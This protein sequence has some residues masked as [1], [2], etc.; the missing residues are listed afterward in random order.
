MGVRI[1]L[2]VA[3]LAVG[4]SSAIMGCGGKTDSPTAESSAPSGWRTAP[5]AVKATVA[6]VNETLNVP[7]FVW[8]SPPEKLPLNSTP[9]SI[10]WGTLRGAA[11]SLKLA[12]TALAAAKINSIHDTGS[13]AIVA[14]FGQTV[15]GLDVFRAELNVSMRRDLSPVAISGSLAPS[16]RRLSAN[17]WSVD[18]RAA[19][20]AAFQAMTGQTVATSS[21]AS[22]GAAAGGFEHYA[23]TV[24]GDYTQFANARI[25]RVWFPDASGIVPAYYVELELANSLNAD[26]KLNSF[27]IGAGKADT[28]YQH[29]MVNADK[30]SYRVWA[31]NTGPNG[32]APMD[33]PYGNGLTPNAAGV[34]DTN[35]LPP[36]YVYSSLVNLQ[37]I[38]FS[39]NDPWLPMGA[40]DLLGGNNVG[41]YADLTAPD[42][43][44]AGGADVSVASTSP[45]VFGHVFDPNTIPGA[46]N[47][48]IQAVTTNL[49][50]VVNYMHD[51]FYDSGYD[52][53]SHNSQQDNYGR[54]GAGAL[55]GDPIHAESQDYSGLDNANCSTPSDGKSPRIQ[56][57]LWDLVSDHH[58]T[59]NNPAALGTLTTV[60]TAV[61][62]VAPWDV[63]GD[64]VQY[65]DAKGGAS[66]A[67]GDPAAPSAPPTPGDP[68]NAAN[69]A[70]LAGKIA[71]VDRGT[72]SFSVKA[73]NARAAGAVAVIVANSATGAMLG[74]FGDTAYATLTSFPGMLVTNADGT[75]IKTA[76]G[77]GT[78]NVE[79]FKGPPTRDGSVD[80]T[81]ISH[82]WGHSLSHRLINNANGLNSTQSNG[83]GEG[84]SDFVALLTYIRP[85]DLDVASNAN[86][87]GVYPLGTYALGAM[88]NDIYFGIRRYPYSYDMTKDP[89]TFKYIQNG[90][91]LPTMPPP[92][93]G[94]N[95]ANNAEVHNTGEVWAVMLWDLYV[96]LLRDT[97]NYNFATAGKQMRDYLVASLKLTPSDP[98]FTE[99]R[100]AWLLA[101]LANTAKPNDFTT[102]ATAFARRGIGVGA[103]APPR[104]A[105]DN[106][107][108]TESFMIGSDLE[109]VTASLDDDVSSCDHDHILDNGETGNLTVTMHNNGTNTL[110]AATVKLSSTTA[111]VVFPAGDTVTFASTAPFATA[112]AKVKVALVGVTGFTTFDIK[113]DLDAPNLVPTPGPRSTTQTFY[114]NYDWAPASSATDD[115]NAPGTLWS[116]SH[117][118]TLADGDW[119]RIPATGAFGQL[120]FNADTG[121]T[122]DQYLASP[123]LHVGSGNFSFSFKHHY[124]FEVDKPTMTTKWFDGGV[125]EASTDGTTW[126]DIGA[127][128]T[129][130]GYTASA[131]LFN[132]PTDP[133]P[134]AG[135]P[136]FL[137]ASAGYPADIVTTVDL[138]T[139]YAGSS[140]LQIR[141][142]VGT[143]SGGSAPGWFVDD[144]AFTG[145]TDT[146]FPSRVPQSASCAPPVANAGPAQ[147]VNEGTTAT[148][149]GTASTAAAG[150]TIGYHWSQL[151]GP[152]VTLSSA[153]ASK[154]TFTAPQVN[155]DMVV[156]MQLFVDDGTLMS[157]PSTVD[158]TVKYVPVVVHDMAMG[159]GGTGGGGGG[160]ATDDMGTG[161]AGGGGGGGTGGTGGGGG[162]GH[163]GCSATGSSGTPTAALPFV[164]L[165]LLGFAL[166]RRSRRS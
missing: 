103:V 51:L 91:A 104:Y 30:Y 74:S 118:G 120:W 161:G 26:G 86:W 107:T 152:S 130:N 77:S 112:Q 5:L 34:F 60:G 32:L 126:T 15:D 40:T 108:V 145:L 92:L 57:Y 129:A 158:I 136:G 99:A 137:G 37:N 47:E 11:P 89:L 13:G 59:I 114:S 102:F 43:Y 16:L 10:A 31:D 61:W 97:A 80:G 24:S 148:L 62:D 52:E 164:G 95:G 87:N 27:V 54:G 83:M 79:L 140:T 75:S 3:V 160:G 29:D 14:R 81:I 45:G 22:H 131:T 38:P 88:P 111:G 98:T 96:G 70:A 123:Q 76:L 166:R 128:A 46:T 105:T 42:G 139:T 122:A 68:A 142:R 12:D 143:D 135:R 134:L 6:H 33:S 132:D 150:K 151:S 93:S 71:L 84:W 64:V 19:A 157:A 119:T 66:L 147:S 55:A 56:M 44:V 82:E 28:L 127:S 63:T 8:L 159:G 144:I 2:G 20:A 25:K 165:A 146:P 39:K 72:C 49:F 65:I 138:G 110:T 163:S 153:T 18:A 149:D 100:D 41:A 121:A 69:A 67:C 106:K 141:F 58:I 9:V 4:F 90:V 53:A 124:S 154:P 133:N 36:S 125:I 156:K 17:G 117:D 73:D 7:S 94:A 116:A 78:V 21:I 113:I 23:F 35:A 162:G 1:R 155:A 109:F 48:N 50:F 101:A 115:V 85:T